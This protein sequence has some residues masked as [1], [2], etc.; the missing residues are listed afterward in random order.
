MPQ[1]LMLRRT[2][3]YGYIRDSPQYRLR[4]LRLPFK[5]DAFFK[6]ASCPGGVITA[7]T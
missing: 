5:L 4:D 1:L 2:D 6:K 3:P 7:Y